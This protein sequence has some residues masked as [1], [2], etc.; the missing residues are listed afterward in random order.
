MMNEYGVQHGPVYLEG[1]TRKEE[2]VKSEE[3]EWKGKL[4]TSDGHD[5]FHIFYYGD[6]TEDDL[7]TWHD[8]TPLLVY[9]E[10]TVTGER[11]LLI[12]AA[13][14][15]YDAMLCETYSEET[16]RDRPLRPYL[17]VEGEDIFEV[18][19]TVYYNVPWDEEFGEDVDENGAYEL[20]TG[21]RMH[22]DQVKRD[23]Y[24]AFAIRILNRKGVWTDIVQE[25]LA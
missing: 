12:D 2:D 10:H 9:A 23:G 16:L 17:D 13:K 11:Y 22:F 1:L 3:V 6:L 18:E 8:S 20:I 7:I 24:D 19:L 4:L 25:E 14:H 21:E 5:K 15:G